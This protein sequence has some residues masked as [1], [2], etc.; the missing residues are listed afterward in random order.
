MIGGDGSNSTVRAALPGV[1]FEA[2]QGSSERNYVSIHCTGDVNAHNEG[3]KAELYFFTSPETEHS[4]FIG[5]GNPSWVY[6]RPVDP[7]KDPLESFTIE[8]CQK[9]INV[10]AGTDIPSQVHSVQIWQTSAKTAT[11]YSE[12]NFKEF[13]AGDSAHTYPPQGGLGVNTGLA[14]AH[15]LVWKI[16]LVE[17]GYASKTRLLSTYTSE[18]RPVA[19]SNAAQSAV[20][21]VHMRQLDTEASAAIEEARESESKDLSDVLRIPAVRSRILGGIEN[22]RDHFDSLGLQL[23][24]IYGSQ[25]LENGLQRENC[26]IYQPSFESGARL[27]HCWL[28][29]PDKASSTLDLV[30]SWKFTVFYQNGGSWRPSSTIRLGGKNVVFPLAVIEVATA[31][32]PDKWVTSAGIDHQTCLVIRPDQHILRAVKSEE[33][34][35]LLLEQTLW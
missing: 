20:N 19:I 31:N 26:S 28:N 27:P 3:R 29:V 9:S 15:N 21:E 11:S 8:R 23:G 22:N 34:L 18:R 6:A 25:S 30:H 32:I 14:D 35:E 7:L 24:Y 4:G 10:A 13:L 16:K 12:E 1:V 33:E 5:Y 17:E 2:L